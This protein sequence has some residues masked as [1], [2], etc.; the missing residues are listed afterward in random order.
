MRVQELLENINFKDDKFVKHTGEKRE[1]DYDLV[2][3]LVHF[4]N[5]DDDIYRR[6]VYPVVTR[7]IDLIKVKKPVSKSLFG[8]LVKEGYKEYVKKF[9]IKELPNELDKKAFKEACSKMFKEVCDD[10]KEGKY[11]D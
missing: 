9:P 1:I 5:N 10:I 11:K 8:D 4:L 6:H 3:D 2:E 7:C